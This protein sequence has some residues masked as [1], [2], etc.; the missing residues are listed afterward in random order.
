[1]WWVGRTMEIYGEDYNA[2]V[3]GIRRLRIKDIKNVYEDK[4][5]GIVLSDFEGDEYSHR[6]LGDIDI[7]IKE[8]HTELNFKK[9]DVFT[10]IFLIYTKLT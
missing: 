8:N 5:Y 3:R 2:F 9:K 6:K 10:V 1:V 7:H 4:R